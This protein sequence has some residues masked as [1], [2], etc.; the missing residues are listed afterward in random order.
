MP[1]NYFQC[2]ICRSSSRMIDIHRSHLFQ[3]ESMTLR[4]SSRL[5]NRW[6]AAVCLKVMSRTIAIALLT[7]SERYFSFPDFSKYA[8]GS[9]HGYSRLRT[10]DCLHTHNSVFALVL[11]GIFVLLEYKRLLGECLLGQS[12]LGQCLLGEYTYRI[13]VYIYI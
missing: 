2:N 5:Y 11:V 6:T 3:L 10:A 9:N 7:I 1:N 13:F 4:M 8:F 12:L